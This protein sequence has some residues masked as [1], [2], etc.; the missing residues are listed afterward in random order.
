MRRI[1]L[2]SWVM[3][4]YGERKVK[5]DRERSSK[6]DGSVVLRGTERDC[7]P[8]VVRVEV[9][10][11]IR[12][13]AHKVIGRRRPAACDTDRLRERKQRLQSEYDNIDLLDNL[14]L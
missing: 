13:C 4:D 1:N 10:Q 9:E 11:T 5:E 8:C 2:A 14:K 12:L 7:R 6:E 3:S